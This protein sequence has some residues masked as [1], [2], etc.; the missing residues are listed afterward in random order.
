VKKL[1]E[2]AY[3][4]LMDTFRKSL[5]KKH[6]LAFDKIQVKNIS[7]QDLERWKEI[8]NLRN[9]K[10]GFSFKDSVERNVVD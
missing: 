9:V 3:P 8:E 1:S 4:V 2:T 5:E 7:D 6:G 10:I